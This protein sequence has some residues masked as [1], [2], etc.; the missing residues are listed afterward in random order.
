[1]EIGPNLEDPE[2]TWVSTFDISK[3]L[4]ILNDVSEIRAGNIDLLMG[5]K[6][7]VDTGTSFWVIPS[8][9]HKIFVEY[10]NQT[11]LALGNCS[12]TNFTF[13]VTKQTY[14]Q[15]IFSF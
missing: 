7:I 13:E 2:P 15:L 10:I 14:Y 11:C 3:R 8:Y 6:P 4:Y 1:M 5:Y 9:P 12:F